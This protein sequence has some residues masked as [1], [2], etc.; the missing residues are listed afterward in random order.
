MIPLGAVIQEL[1]ESSNRRGLNLQLPCDGHYQPGDLRWAFGYDM[2]T[3]WWALV[4]FRWLETLAATGQMPVMTGTLLTPNLLRRVF[5]KTHTARVTRRERGTPTNPGTGHDVLALLACMR[6]AL[7]RELHQY[8]HLDLTS[9]DTIS[10]AYALQMRE[11]FEETFYVKAGEVDQRW[12]SLIAEYAEVVQIGRTHLQY[13]LPITVGCWLAQLRNRFAASVREAR[14]LSRAIPGKASGAVGTSAA[15][16]HHFGTNDLEVGLLN[17]LRLPR[18]LQSTQITPPEA[19]VRF[20]GE[21]VLTSGSL[22]NLGEDVRL[23]QSSDIG[24]LTSIGSTSSTMAHKTGNPVAAENMAG[25]HGS[26]LGAYTMVLGT[27]VSDLQRDLRG[28]SVMRGFGGVLCYTYQQLLT[29]DRL[30]KSLRVNEARCTE[31]LQ[32]AGPCVTAEL[33]YV[34]LL[35][36]GFANAHTLVNKVIVPAARATGCDL[37]V[38]TDTVIKQTRNRR[39]RAAWTLVPEETRRQIASPRDYLGDAVKLAVRTAHDQL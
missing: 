15:L 17:S 30:L 24:E 27:L 4:E 19:F 1:K 12:R 13:A 34:S 25:M 39:L 21:I 36:A 29:A 2:R 32:K 35:H 8:L 28:S 22:A 26:V 37:V 10:T 5:E 7:P 38:A 23:L 31:N 33:L 9:Y 14:K 16:R 20:L 18:P 11:A 3:S 6:Q